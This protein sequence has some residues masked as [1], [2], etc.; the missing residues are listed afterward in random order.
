VWSG[1]RGYVDVAGRVADDGRL[2]LTGQAAPAGYDNPTSILERFDVELDSLQGLRVRVRTAA[3][4]TGGL[5]AY[6]GQVE[7]SVV[8]AQR[9]PLSATFEGHWSG[10]YEVVPCFV[11]EGCFEGKGEFELILTERGS[12][13]DGE[14]VVRLNQRAAVTGTTDGAVANFSGR[15]PDYEIRDV[16]VQRDVVG[17]LSG[18]VTLVYGSKARALTLVRVGRLTDEP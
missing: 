7:G 9:A 10:Y 4:H 14:A 11:S 18:S 13:L 2:S 16:R 1:R 8:S 3:V 12:V 6:S 15:G 17:R 5:S